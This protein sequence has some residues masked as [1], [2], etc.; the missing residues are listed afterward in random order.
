M[1]TNFHNL[2]AYLHPDFSW[3]DESLHFLT[4]RLLTLIEDSETWRQAFGF[5]KTGSEAN[6]SQGKKVHEHCLEVAARLFREVD[7]PKEWQDVDLKDLGTVVK[8]RITKY[9]CNSLLSLRN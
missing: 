6:V 4:D 1:C 8:N 5:I 3:S 2:E 9:T 7:S